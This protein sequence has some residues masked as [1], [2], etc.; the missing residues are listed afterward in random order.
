[1]PPSVI[2]E[3]NPPEGTVLNANAYVYLTTSVGRLD[4][5]GTG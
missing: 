1:V 2:I 3:Q 5:N 4:E